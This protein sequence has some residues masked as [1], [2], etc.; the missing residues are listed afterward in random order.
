MWPVI[1]QIGPLTLHPYGL[2]VGLGFLAGYGWLSY[3]SRRRGW[4]HSLPD[5][6]FVVFLFSGL[7][8]ARLLYVAIE[9][10]YYKDHLLDVFRIWSGGLVF[11]GG[12]V[13]AILA[14]FFTLRRKAL[15]AASVADAAA[16]GLALGQAFGRLGCFSAGCCYGLPTTARWGVVFSNPLSL[17]PLNVRIHPTQLY[18]SFL[19]LL[20]FLILAWRNHL[21]FPHVVSGNPASLNPR[22]RG[23]DGKGVTA[24]LYLCFYGLARFLVEFL[25]GDDRGGFWRGMSPSQ[26]L[27]IAGVAV[28]LAWFFAVSLRKDAGKS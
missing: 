7:L 8:G 4:P 15:P 23:D 11:Y 10:S 16:P 19:D 1:A 28:G 20:I 27:S 26:W 12:L 25:R 22:V 2:L 17:A 24:A 3:E 18:E 9:W 6:L 21:S 13:C 14:G 5:N